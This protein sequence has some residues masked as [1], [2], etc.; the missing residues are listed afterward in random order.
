MV[1]LVGDVRRL[2][3]FAVTY[4]A[5]GIGIGIGLG[6]VLSDLKYLAVIAL[7]NR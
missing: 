6:I 2:E 5:I 7:M 4:L 3:L 1:R